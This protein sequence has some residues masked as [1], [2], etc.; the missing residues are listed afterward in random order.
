M[1]Y[2]VII[3]VHNEQDSV[4]DVYTAIKAVMAGLDGPYEILFVDDG[5][6]DE[7]LPRLQEMQSRHKDLGIVSLARRNGEA[8]ALQAGFD[9]ACGEIYIT[10]DGDGQDDPREIPKLLDKMA[11]GY[12]V[13]H[14]WRRQRKDNLLKKISSCLANSSRRLVTGES[15]HD[16]GCSLRVFRGRDARGICLY[17][18]FHRFFSLIMKKKG[19]R[20]G[21]TEVLHHWRKTGASKYGTWKR[22]KEGTADLFL[23]MFGDFEKLMSRPSTYTIKAVYRQ[24][25]S[26]A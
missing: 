24:K 14:G 10:L 15:L 26:Y 2:S 16:F 7:T 20:I 4:Q 5:S 6:L 1:K 3:P 22:L 18:G 21:E 25:E 17:R 12:D 8:Q 9:C 13:I 19:C 23:L 11:Q